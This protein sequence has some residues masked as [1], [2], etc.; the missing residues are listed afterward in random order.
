MATV[1]ATRPA[2]VTVTDPQTR[3]DLGHQ[4][5]RVGAAV[6]ALHPLQDQ[7]VAG[8]QRQMEMR[9]QPRFAADQLYVG[10]RFN[11]AKGNLAGIT[12]D[13]RVQRLHP[14]PA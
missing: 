6:A 11:V 9:H 8:L 3:A 13:L 7:I 5:E 14:M 2:T 4:P 1:D 12:G 10:S